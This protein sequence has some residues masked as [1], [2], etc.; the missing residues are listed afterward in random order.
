[1]EAHTFNTQSWKVILTFEI[2]LFADIR[3]NKVSGFPE[4]RAKTLNNRVGYPDVLISLQ[5]QGEMTKSLFME[6]LR[7]AC[8]NQV[9]G[10]FS[11]ET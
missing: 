7:L 3:G 9:P 2:F 4:R 10:H 1:M 8:K 11:V 6:K 5:I